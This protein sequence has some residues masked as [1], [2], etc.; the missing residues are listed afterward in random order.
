MTE[1]ECDAMIAAVCELFPTYRPNEAERRIWGSV[2]RPFSVDLASAAIDGYKC[3]T[4]RG[5]PVAGEVRRRL[6]T[7]DENRKAHAESRG[8]TRAA[9]ERSGHRRQ[10]EDDDAMARAWISQAGDQEV[11][12]MIPDISRIVMMMHSGMIERA[13]RGSP[14]WLQLAHHVMPQAVTTARI[15]DNSFLRG[16]AFALATKGGQ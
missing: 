14:K 4:V 7:M 15:R 12:A 10:A 13:D 16:L 8:E 6:L 9:R 3:E 11:A 2:F 5:W 1:L